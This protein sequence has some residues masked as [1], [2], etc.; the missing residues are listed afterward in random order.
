MRKKRNKLIKQKWPLLNLNEFQGL[1]IKKQ[2]EICQELKL[3]DLDYLFVLSCVSK[4]YKRRDW[5]GM[6]FEMY[7]S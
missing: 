7:H 3:I 6:M 1:V 4:V 5:S 2:T